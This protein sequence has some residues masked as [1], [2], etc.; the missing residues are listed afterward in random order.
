MNHP[1]PLHPVLAG[2][3]DVRFQLKL[4]RTLDIGLSAILLTALS[5]LL[6]LIALAVKATSPG[7]VLHRC[8]WV[9][10]DAVPFDGYKFRTMVAGADALEAD[11]QKLNEMKGPAFKLTNDPRIT[12]LGRFLR[13]YSLDELPQLVSVLK[14]D[15]SLVGPRPPRTHEYARFTPFQAQK[16]A[17]TPGLTCLWQI[18]G[19]HRITDYDEWVRLDLDYID[20]WSLGLDLGILARTLVVV[21]RGTGA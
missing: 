7:P 14:G 3:R 18:Q 10:K 2:G 8:A 6:A 12:P 20:R 13:K 5:P 4:K 17:V 19:R 1:I 15:M 21:L 16:L 11:L 9:G